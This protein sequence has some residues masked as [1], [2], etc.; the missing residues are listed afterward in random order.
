MSKTSQSIFGVLG[1]ISFKDRI[2]FLKPRR[3]GRTKTPVL[4]QREYKTTTRTVHGRTVCTV[5]PLEQTAMAEAG[6]Q[7]NSKTRPHIVYFHGGGYSMEASGLHFALMKTLIKQTGCAL[8][9]VDYPLAPEHTAT[10]TVAMCMEAY[11]ILQGE[12]PT[13]SFVFVGDSAGGGLALALAMKIRDDALTG[14]EKSEQPGKLAGPEQLILFSPWLDI[15]LGNP[16]IPVYQE[17]DVILEASGLRKIAEVYRGELPS[18]HFLVSPI[19]GNLDGLGP[20][21][22]FYGTEEILYPDCKEFCQESLN[23]GF[24]VKAYEYKGMQHDWV[25]L[26]TPEARQAIAQ[27][28]AMIQATTP[29]TIL[30]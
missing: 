30:P 5:A 28:C 3:S 7:G 26:P 19:H 20:I 11:K 24:P 1:A 13:R 29:A 12:H 4:P 2:D 9:Y 8:T 18:D 16:L 14:L 25:I 17:K 21:A 22:V 15:S 6:T 23:K 10:E 27:V